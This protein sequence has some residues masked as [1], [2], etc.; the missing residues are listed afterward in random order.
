MTIWRMQKAFVPDGIHVPMSAIDHDWHGAACSPPAEVTLVADPDCLWLLARR[1]SA[2]RPDPNAN[3]GEFREGLWQH[4]VAELF[5]AAADRKRYLEFNLSPSG[6]W[7]FAGFSAARERVTGHP[8][9]QVRTLAF[10]HANDG[11]TAALGIPIDFLNSHVAWGPDSSLNITLILNSPDPQ[12]L[13]AAALGAGDPD[14]HR[15]LHF[16]ALEWRD[17]P[18]TL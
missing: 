1:A 11:W 12:F 7:W 6:A 2:A 8:L 15:P 18:P 16:S 3:L 17:L 13:S 10:P 5:I 4:D 9:P 14:F